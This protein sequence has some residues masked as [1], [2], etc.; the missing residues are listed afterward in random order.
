MISSASAR[1]GRVPASPESKGSSRST[2][3]LLA[4]GPESIA[5][6]APV[7]YGVLL[8]CAGVVGSLD[9]SSAYGSNTSLFGFI[10]LPCA[11]TSVIQPAVEPGAQLSSYGQF[12]P[13]TR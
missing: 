2:M 8:G 7:E 4:T 11:S 9:S 5:R 13:H 6:F 12:G 1:G 10:R 3:P